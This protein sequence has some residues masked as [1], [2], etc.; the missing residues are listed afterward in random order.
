[1]S[2]LN[3]LVLPSMMNGSRPV[4]LGDENNPTVLS[5]EKGF[6]CR[7]LTRSFDPCG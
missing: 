1:M 3:H 6:G 4:C 7:V 2:P 5:I